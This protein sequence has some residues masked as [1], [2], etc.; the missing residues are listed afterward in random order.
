LSWASSMMRYGS[1]PASSG[2]HAA[3]EP[4]EYT[5][6]GS[7]PRRARK[8]AGRR[9]SARAS[10]AHPSVGRGRRAAADRGRVEAGLTPASGG[11]DTGSSTG[12]AWVEGSPPRRAGKTPA[13]GR[14][15]GRDVAHPHVGRGRLRGPPFLAV[16]RRLTPASGGEDVCSLL[17]IDPKLGSP[18]RQT[19]KTLLDLKLYAASRNS[20]FTR[21]H[22]SVPRRSEGDAVVPRCSSSPDAVDRRDRFRSCRSSPDS[23]AASWAGT[24]T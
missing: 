6:P 17:D 4:A 7:P 13:V 22:D 20:T 8:T 23:A 9:R 2:D 10:R 16:V 19:G 15:A 18:P 1:P 11:G 24:T 21:R 5:M 3:P 12:L 14:G